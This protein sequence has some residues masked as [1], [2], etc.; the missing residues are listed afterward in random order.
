MAS[1]AFYLPR[2]RALRLER[3]LSQRDLAAAAGIAHVTITALERGRQRAQLGTIRKLALALDVP[4]A[5]LVRQDDDGKET[6]GKD[7]A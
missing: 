1:G 3:A 6:T 4:V 5:E 2:L 7:A